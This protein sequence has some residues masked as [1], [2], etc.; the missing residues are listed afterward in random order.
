ML[1]DG[2]HEEVL[3]DNTVSLAQILSKDESGPRFI[4]GGN[5]HGDVC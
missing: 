1:Y 4:R 5:M 2:G 3:T